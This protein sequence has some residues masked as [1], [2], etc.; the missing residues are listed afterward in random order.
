MPAN[1]NR[2]AQYVRERDEALLALD[3]AMIKAFAKRW[4][5]RF[6]LSWLGFWGGVH[7]AR[8]NITT[9]PRAER[10]KSLAWLAAHGL[11]PMIGA[12]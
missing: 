2:V 3:E 9:F 4:G 11:T 8:A 7:K 6:E 10:E 1:D 5:L 12:R